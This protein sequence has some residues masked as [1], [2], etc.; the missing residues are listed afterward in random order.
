VLTRVLRGLSP[1]AIGIAGI[2]IGLVPIAVA[3]NPILIR[4][5]VAALIIGLFVLISVQSPRLAILL[6]L[7][8]LPLLAFLRRLLIPVGG[9]TSYDALLLVA[10]IVAVFLLYRVFILQR[11]P[12]APDLAS[13]AVL[14]LIVLAI[15]QVINPR[16]G[17]LTAGAT[18][19][20]F[21]AAPL[22][23]FFLGRELADRRFMGTVVMG[24]VILAVGIAGYGLWQTLVGLLPWDAAWTDL[25]GY[26]ALSV[27]GAT[28]AFGTFSSGAEYAFF[29]GIALVTAIV[30]ALHGRAW[31]LLAVPILGW[32]IFLESSRAIIFVLLLGI[33]ALLGIR[34][35]RK[36]V[37]TLAI[38]MAA[39]V[40]VG[41]I[42]FF[43]PQLTA[44]AQQTGSPF[45]AHQ[46]AGLMNPFD[47]TQS[48]LALHQQ[49]V[50][51]GFLGSLADPLGA[52][53]ASTNLAGQKVSG[54]SNSTEMDLINVFVSLGV[55]GG[56]AFTVVIVL[57]LWRGADRALSTLGMVELAAIGILM[58]TFGQWLNGGFYAVAPLLWVLVGWTNREWLARRRVGEGLS[59]STVPAEARVA[60]RSSGTAGWLVPSV[61]LKP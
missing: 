59:V 26:A 50:A 29:L 23:W 37:A 58:V 22:G 61:E 5:A 12:L 13:K 32:A 52:G 45:V 44:A 1:L 41:T 11:R 3:Q 36:A 6:V 2:M 47:S 54:S 56:I 39:T 19:L 33:A 27:F 7:W 34:T 8:F 4:V 38:G 20:L 40:A 43:G 24:N 53:T 18:G 35:G 21:V 51:N 9:W 16:G 42:H 25:N 48:T 60:V 30:L 14:I 28:R 57:T 55:F 46:V 17:G 31:A 15:V 49:L 10:P